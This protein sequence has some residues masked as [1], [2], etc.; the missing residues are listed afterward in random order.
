MCHIAAK[1]TRRS[2]QVAKKYFG[3]NSLQSI[4]F[5]FT[6]V[7]LVKKHLNLPTF[8][9]KLA[10]KMIFFSW[11]ESEKLAFPF[12]Y[13]LNITTGIFQATRDHGWPKQFGDSE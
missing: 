7:K 11:I 10:K 6:N 8:I 2:G 12:C 5:L 3:L 4:I 13:S 9:S 1:I